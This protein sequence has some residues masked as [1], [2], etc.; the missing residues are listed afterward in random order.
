MKKQLC[1]MISVICFNLY[2]DSSITLDQQQLQQAQQDIQ[3]QGNKAIQSMP[4]ASATISNVKLKQLNLGETESQIALAQQQFAKSPKLQN[5]LPT[6]EKYYLFSESVVSDNQA[7][8]AKVKKPIDINQAISDYNSLREN[9]KAKINN[10]RLIVF[11]SRS[12][13]KKTIV[14]LMSQASA[15]GAVFVVR[16]LIDGSYTKTTKYFYDL[17]GDNTVGVMINPTLFKAM[18]VKT[19]PTFALYQGEQDILT[20]ACSIAPKYS[21]V[22]GDVS[23][24]YALEMLARSKNLDLAQIA[25]NEIEILDNSGFYKK[26][27]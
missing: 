5:R 27:K 18:D 1:F 15:I 12:M 23:V 8:L 6:G 16:G 2:A 9:A 13:P 19:V 10:N 25:N 20:T 17:K 7:Y 11:I 22:S 14:N 21:K 4:Q 26:R 3:A 24:H